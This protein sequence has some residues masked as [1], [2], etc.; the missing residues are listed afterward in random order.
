MILAESSGYLVSA[1]AA[2]LEKRHGY[3]LYGGKPPD[4]AANMAGLILYTLAWAYHIG[5][6]LYYRQ[7]WFLVTWFI[8]L[9]L[10]TAGYAGRFASSTDVTNENDFMVQIICLTLAPAFLMGGVYYL[11]GKMAMVYGPDNSPLKPMH[12]SLIFILCDLFS[13]IIQGAG[14]GVSASAS[15]R[16]KNTKPGTNLT[17][18][19]MALQIACLL[20]FS[21]FFG[22]FMWTVHKK[23]DQSLF[24][25]RYAH[26]RK[27]WAFRAL[28]WAI[29]WSVLCVFI[30]SVYRTAEFA[31]GW[32][33]RL[34]LTERYFLVLDGLFILLA[35]L[36]LSVVHPGFAFGKEVIPVKGFHWNVKDRHNF[37]SD[38]PASDEYAAEKS[39]SAN[40][41]Q[42]HYN[43]VTTSEESEH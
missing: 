14:G 21:G 25:P 19:G 32:S 43:N 36:G 39:P 3:Y 37:F 40:E 9:G 6:G 7:W 15:D 33:G 10:E 41:K 16:G 42:D 8:G 11:L 23:R 12:Y 24:N 34:I 18:A 27:R 38:E 29:S 2:S 31:D 17:V 5:V 22:H 26:I 20:L 30:R 1:V 35:V 28:P 13:I 4:H